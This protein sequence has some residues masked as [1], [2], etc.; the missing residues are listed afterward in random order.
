MLSD[1]IAIDLGLYVNNAKGFIEYNLPQFAVPEIESNKRRFDP[2]FNSSAAKEGSMKMLKNTIIGKLQTNEGI[3][4]LCMELGNTDSD[5]SIIVSFES[6]ASTY[7]QIEVYE[8]IKKKGI[9]TGKLVIN[10]IIPCINNIDFISEL[11]KECREVLLYGF[12]NKRVLS[13]Y[14]FAELVVTVKYLLNNEHQN[15]SIIFEKSF[16]N[17]RYTSDKALEQKEKIVAALRELHVEEEKIVKLFGYRWLL[18]G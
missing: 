9:S 13:N 4:A 15:Y 8:A 6:D 14:L 2:D 7:Q 12:F 17:G 5:G 1:S 16:N 3:S 10:G 11:S 18:E